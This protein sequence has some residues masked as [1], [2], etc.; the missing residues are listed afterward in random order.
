MVDENFELNYKYNGMLLDPFSSS[1]NYV[2]VACLFKFTS[3]VTAEE[4]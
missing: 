2:P 1:D 3:V 4:L